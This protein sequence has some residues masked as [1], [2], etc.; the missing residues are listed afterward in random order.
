MST[1]TATIQMRGDT[2]ANWAANNPTL[3]DREV[4]IETDTRRMK[5][6]N[7]TQA[8]N[9]LAYMQGTA[10][11]ADTG[12]GASNVPTIADA[13]AR[14]SRFIVKPT[15]TARTNNTLSAD[16]FLVLP[17]D[18]N[19]GYSGAIILFVSASAAGRFKSRITGPAAPT[20]VLLAQ[21]SAIGPTGGTTGNR[22]AAAYDSSDLV[23][24]HTVDFVLRLQI[25]F[26]VKNGPN[27]G[28]LTVEWAQNSTSANATTLLAGSTIEYVQF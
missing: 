9:S 15:D 21:T 28:N 27:A 8:W 17:M 26:T 18:A 10:A 20:S 4:G 11:Q 24:L 1:I 6:G 2:A 7:G 13:D 5:L 3:L 25:Q 23:Q 16:P 19:T 22:V 12:T 14:Y